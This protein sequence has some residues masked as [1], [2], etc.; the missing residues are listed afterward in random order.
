M[1]SGA[2]LVG[3]GVVTV[4]ADDSQ[5][6]EALNKMPALAQSKIDLTMRSIQDRIAKTRFNLVF[7]TDPSKIRQLEGSLDMLERRMNNVKLAAIDTGNAMGGGLKAGSGRG[8]QALYQVGAA[9]DDLQ[10]GFRGIL[11]N[12]P[13]IAI[14]FGH[15]G[16]AGAIAIAV[17]AVYQLATHY[18]DLM[19]LMGMGTIQTEAEAMKEL[20]KQTHLTAMEQERLNR[21][22]LQE[23]TVAEIREARSP[24]EEKSSK[25]IKEAIFAQGEKHIQEALGKS[26][27]VPEDH[28]NPDRDKQLKNIAKAKEIIAAAD[29]YAASSGR[30]RAAV[31]AEADKM[32]HEAEKKLSGI[33]ETEVAEFQANI[34]NNK[35]GRQ[36]AFLKDVEAH[37]EKYGKGKTDAEKAA[38]GKKF[39]EALK[40]GTP[41]AVEKELAAKTPEAKA[42]TKEAKHAEKVRK[43]VGAT[44]RRFGQAVKRSA[45]AQARKNVAAAKADAAK[46]ARAARGFAGSMSRGAIGRKLLRNPKADITNDVIA[47]L[48]GQGVKAGKARDMAGEVAAAIRESVGKRVSDR[49]GKFGGTAAEA[50]A[51]LA[52]KEEA[53]A[54]RKAARAAATKREAGQRV[55]DA[56]ERVHDA[57]YKVRQAFMGAQKSQVMDVHSFINQQLTSSLNGEDRQRELLEAM[58]DQTRAERELKDAIDRKKDLIAVAAP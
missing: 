5:F 14:A 49:V 17:T 35:G 46:R 8:A 23:K 19:N 1:S 50:G 45:A 41:E 54:N 15:A 22:K 56:E 4:K 52:D 48:M 16:L 36:A 31:I 9:V 13:Q 42:A 57:K 39:L 26:G 10:Y 7:E 58:K 33:R 24:V 21:A 34:I 30:T 51:F 38:S 44:L 28:P 20:A 2:Q 29:L 27:I 43:G 3:A 6:R 37:P 40:K 11:N 18:N 32:I 55:E 53:D 12:I 25:E 47:N